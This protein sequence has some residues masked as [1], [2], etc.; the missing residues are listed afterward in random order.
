MIKK[1]LSKRNAAIILTSVLSIAMASTV[2]AAPGSFGGN[3]GPGGKAGLQGEFLQQGQMPGF[4]E[5]ERPELPTFEEGEQPEFPAFEEGERPELPTFENGERPEPP[6]FDESERPELPDGQMPETDDENR[7][8][9]PEGE[10]PGRPGMMEGRGMNGFDTESV[11]TAIEG[12]DDEEMKAE[13]EALQEEYREAKAALDAAIEEGSEDI[14]TYQKAEMEAMKAL[15]EALDAAGIDMRPELPEGETGERPEFEAE[16]GQMERQ[17]VRENGNGAAPDDQ[18]PS[19]SENSEMTNRNRTD[20][21][22]NGS[23]ER[24]L[25]RFVNWLKSLFS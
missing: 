4:E 13:L 19:L 20:S 3:G 11:Q 18:M 24:T 5:G 10:M 16:P 9:L 14:D 22:T 2:M 12:L 23:S 6:I 17:T 7:P 15:R 21:G 1:R 8:E 25:D